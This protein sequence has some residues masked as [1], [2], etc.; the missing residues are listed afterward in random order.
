MPSFEYDLELGDKHYVRWTWGAEHNQNFD[1]SVV[2]Q[3]H[4]PVGLVLHHETPEGKVCVGSITFDLP[5]AQRFGARHQWT[6]ESWLP[7]TLSPS[8]HCHCGD[9][10]FIRDGSW[11]RA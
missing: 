7:L 3:D 4:R 10:G 8:L 1:G 5:E 2:E 6:V 9:H 11:H